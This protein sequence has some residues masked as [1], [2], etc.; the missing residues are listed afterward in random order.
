[1]NCGVTQCRLTEVVQGVDDILAMLLAF[2][3][4]KEELDIL[5]LT[6]TFGN[7][8]VGKYVFSVFPSIQHIP[9][10]TL[11]S[12]RNS[13]W[14]DYG[15]KRGEK[16][17]GE[18]REERGEE[19]REERRGEKKKKLTDQYSCL[20]NV[21]TLFQHIEKER[22]WRKEHGRPEGFETLDVR[23]PVGTSILF[24]TAESCDRGHDGR[25]AN[26]SSGC[27]G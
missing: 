19:R 8:E 16:I 13:I 15:Y 20:R 4:R 6:L 26:R 12:P 17:R 10:F 22:K 11:L 18:R 9:R 14:A 3:A 7:V 5:A 23:K 24:L 21:V 1:L 27:G 2:S 25:F